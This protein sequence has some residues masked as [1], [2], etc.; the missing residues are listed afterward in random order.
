MNPCDFADVSRPETASRGVTE[1]ET[2]S[3][4]EFLSPSQNPA[5]SLNPV[6]VFLG[7]AGSFGAGGSGKVFWVLGL[8]TLMLLVV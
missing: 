5:L 8:T 6:V 4:G 7:D 2:L 3:N 1:S